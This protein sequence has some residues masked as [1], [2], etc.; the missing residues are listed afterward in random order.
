VAE[1]VWASDDWNDSGSD[2]YFRTLASW[3]AL[4]AVKQKNFA[5]ALKM[6]EKGGYWGN[7]IAQYDAGMLYINGADGVAVDKVRGIAWL[8]IADQ[9]HVEHD[10]H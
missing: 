6:Y 3:R 9:R 8:G 1:T 2:P 7:K 4:D 10:Q 5:E